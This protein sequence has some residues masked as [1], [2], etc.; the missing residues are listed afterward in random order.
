MSPEKEFVDQVVGTD[1]LIQ[2][3]ARDQ[4]IELRR[5]AVAI[6]PT[7]SLDEEWF[8]ARDGPTWDEAKEAEFQDLL[9]NQQSRTLFPICRVNRNAY[10]YI[11]DEGLLELM[12]H[13]LIM[14]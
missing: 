6:R 13:I 5:R 1:P 10:G 14:F 12:D 11:V 7:P 2:S 8:R 4:L 9:F 3:S